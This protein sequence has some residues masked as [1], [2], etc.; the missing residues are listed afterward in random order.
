MEISRVERYIG[1]KHM[2]HMQRVIQKVEDLKYIQIGET[3]QH[4]KVTFRETIEKGWNYFKRTIESFDRQGAPIQGSKHIH[5]VF[6]EEANKKQIR[7]FG[8]WI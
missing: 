5:E 7:Q 8:V 4:N 6:G 2:N 1:P 3:V